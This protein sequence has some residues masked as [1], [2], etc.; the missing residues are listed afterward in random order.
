M[1]V[2]LKGD[3]GGFLG[4]K[5]YGV[6]RSGRGQSLLKLSGQVI[7]SIDQRERRGGPVGYRGRT[8]A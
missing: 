4:P 2:P 7:V 1:T 3:P 8:S 6:C 5:D